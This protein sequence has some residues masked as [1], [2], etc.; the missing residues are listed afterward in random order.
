MENKPS[1]DKLIMQIGEMVEMMQNYK[2][3]ISPDKTPL[4]L[5]ELDRLEQAVNVIE[6]HQQDAFKEAN[7]DIEKLIQESLESPVSS[8][9]Q[10]QLKR[11]KEIEVDIRAFQLALSQAMERKKGRK[12]VK[13]TPTDSATKQQMKERRKLFKSIG[14]DKNWIPL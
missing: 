3:P 7:I 14:G 1:I 8:K 12:K 6:E 10:Q 13:Q 4:I 5:A 9:N 2:E 11:A